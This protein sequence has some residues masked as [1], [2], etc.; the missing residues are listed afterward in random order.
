MTFQS[1]D[2]DT[3]FILTESVGKL[4]YAASTAVVLTFEIMK[5]LTH[6][7]TLSY[8]QFCSSLCALTIDLRQPNTWP[9]LFN[10]CT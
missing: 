3:T 4:K 9:E 5:L 10:Y 7:F 1:N 8:Y 6:S 2:E